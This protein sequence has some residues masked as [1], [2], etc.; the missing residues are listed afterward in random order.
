MKQTPRHTLRPEA[1]SPMTITSY[2]F[3][4]L[5]LSTFYMQLA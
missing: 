2:S 4:L 3:M 5:S 1:L